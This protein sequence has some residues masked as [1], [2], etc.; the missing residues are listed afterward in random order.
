[1]TPLAFEQ[2]SFCL[3]CLFGPVDFLSL[4]AVLV[5]C[6]LHGRNPRPCNH[7]KGFC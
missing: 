5:I 7:H 4:C 2:L 3:L 1:M 6:T